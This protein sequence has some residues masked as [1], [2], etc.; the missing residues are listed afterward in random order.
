[1]NLDEQFQA[2]LEQA[3][4]QLEAQQARSAAFAT[5]AGTI[6]GFDG[7]ILA[8]FAGSTDLSGADGLVGRLTRASLV[9]ITLSA[10][11]TL[12]ALVPRKPPV[13]DWTRVSDAWAN[14]HASDPKIIEGR[15]LFAQLIFAHG[16]EDTERPRP[17]LLSWRT[18]SARTP[19]EGASE[20]A[21]SRGNWF[22][23]SVLLLLAGLVLLLASLLAA[24]TDSTPVTEP[25]TVSTSDPGGG[26]HH[27]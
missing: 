26:E 6:L 8:V 4:W 18:K 21:T 16:L 19:I 22:A 20:M 17:S 2:F 11:C 10:F 7:V 24:P 25:K 23:G 12:G 14:M 1:M 27:G 15:Q 13:V 5:A 9:A 3:R